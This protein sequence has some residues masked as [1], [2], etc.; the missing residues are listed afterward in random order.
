MDGFNGWAPVNKLDKDVSV[1][2]LVGMAGNVS[3]WTATTVAD[4]NQPGVEMAWVKGASFM[5]K[6]PGDLSTS[7]ARS[8]DKASVDRGFRIAADGLQ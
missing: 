4:P 7:L 2:G 6:E 3:E 5:T 1:D 8:P